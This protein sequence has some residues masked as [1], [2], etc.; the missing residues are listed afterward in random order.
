MSQCSIG[1][2]G[3]DPCVNLRFFGITNNV[4]NVT[5]KWTSVV[6]DHTNAIFDLKKV[7]ESKEKLRKRASG[8]LSWLED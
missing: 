7:R 1:V 6:K 2:L 5:N 4:F 8:A 3:G